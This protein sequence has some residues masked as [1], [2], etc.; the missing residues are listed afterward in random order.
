M[1]PLLVI[2]F[3]LYGLG[4]TLLSAL[5]R[6]ER[7]A[8]LL[9]AAHCFV[10]AI[11]LEAIRRLAVVPGPLPAGVLMAMILAY[12]CADLG[13]DVFVNGHARWRRLWLGLLFAGAGFQALDFAVA[14]PPAAR[15]VAYD[16]TIVGLLL[17][18]I[19]LIRKPLHREFGRWGALAWAP[20]AL[21]ALFVVARIAE[22]ALDPASVSR[23]PPAPLSN[24]G[25]VAST[26]IAAA[27]F[28]ISFLGLVIGRLI[29]DLR[30]LVHTDSLTELLNRSG[31]ERELAAAWRLGQHHPQPLSIAFID[32]DH[33]KRFNDLG[34]HEAGD[35]ILKRVAEALQHHARDSDRVGRWAGDEFLVLMRHTG[36]AGALQAM[37]RIQTFVRSAE[38]DLPPGSPALSLS[39]GVA[40]RRAEDQDVASL[41]ARADA[42][43][44]DAK[45]QGRDTIVLA[46]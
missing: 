20:G 40:T 25:I 33:F 18:P 24:P 44:Y 31:I 28:N 10:Q 38:V 21:F 11:G 32:V 46:S 5:V 12:T 13:I 2:Q 3:V 4:W 16:A 45:R 29:A 22:I 7:R 6:E 41:I 23:N 42:G 14:L 26:L 36:S 15:A 37:Q 1:A 35:R 8:S 19:L 17:L 27:A 39:I 30:R 34:T 43:M 9:W